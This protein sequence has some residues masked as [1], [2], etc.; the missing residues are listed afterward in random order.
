ML[1]DFLD[2]YP[3]EMLTTY[4][5]N[6]NILRMIGRVA[7]TIY[8]LE[9]DKLLMDAAASMPLATNIGE[10]HYH[11]NRYGKGGLYRGDDPAVNPLTPTSDQ[12]K[13]CFTPLSNTRHALIVAAQ[14]PK[15]ATQ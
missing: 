15:G 8:P 4:T 2:R 1:I 14:V 3:V 9:Q 13:E 5:R 11:I 6:P 10:A 7:T 12:L